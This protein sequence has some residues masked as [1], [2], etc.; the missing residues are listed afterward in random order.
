M[1]L[2]TAEAAGQLAEITENEGAS[3]PTFFLFALGFV[4][5]TLPLGILFTNLSQRLSVKR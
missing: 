2:G 5:L 1:I 4:I 3:L